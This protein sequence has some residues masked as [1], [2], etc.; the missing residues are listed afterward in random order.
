MFVNSVLL[1][2]S[3]W[4]S[5]SQFPK[6]IKWNPVDMLVQPAID[7]LT[8]RQIDSSTLDKMTNWHLDSGLF[9]RTASWQ[10]DKTISWLFDRFT[11]KSWPIDRARVDKMTKLW[12]WNTV[13]NVLINYTAICFWFFC[14]SLNAKKLMINLALPIPV[15]H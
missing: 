13:V 7:K 6:M 9:D 5:P 2:P 14:F 11:D 1:Y 4:F 10:I 3:L 12:R 8:N 15:L